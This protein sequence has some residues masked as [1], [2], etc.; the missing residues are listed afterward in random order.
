MFCGDCGRENTAGRKFC[1]D[2]GAALTPTT[3]P[4]QVEHRDAPACED[5]VFL[6]GEPGGP[7]QPAAPIQPGGTSE[8]AVSGIAPLAGPQ[9]APAC[10]VDLEIDANKVYRTSELGSL[11]LRVTN[12]CRDVVDA[13]LAVTCPCL[14]QPAK[15]RT[16]KGLVP[17]RSRIVHVQWRPAHGGE[18]VLDLAL[19]FNDPTG[20]EWALSGDTVVVVARPGE[21]QSSSFHFDIHDIEKFM[22][23]DLSGLVRIGTLGQQELDPDALLA[24]YRNRVPLWMAIDLQLEHGPSDRR[25]IDRAGAATPRRALASLVSTDG[26]TSV[27]FDL[28]TGPRVRLGKLPRPDNDI[29]LVWED[30]SPQDERGKH[31]SRRQFELVPTAKGISFC[32]SKQGGPTTY[33]GTAL[34][35]TGQS[36]PL[37]EVAAVML[38]TF[39][40]EISIAIVQDTHATRDAAT[41]ARLQKHDPGPDQMPADCPVSA[42]RLQRRNNALDLQYCWILRSAIVGSDPSCGLP[43][44][45]ASIA[46]RHARIMAWRGRFYLEDLASAGTTV[47]DGTTLGRGDIVALGQAHEIRFGSRVF[48]WALAL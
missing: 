35:A 17:S 13:S 15:D 24:R 11:D 23:N 21:Q 26:A 30:E 20:G 33:L 27:R 5:D 18:A 10:H 3:T 8:P 32:N 42:V 43:V 37:P 16:L 1:A 36:V 14:D 45:D 7:G 46:P 29:C 44:T 2:C 48:R 19:T 31:I 4:L 34:L 22:G 40:L 38:G 9:P 12:R 6:C 28:V 47:V 25:I 41:S 39:V